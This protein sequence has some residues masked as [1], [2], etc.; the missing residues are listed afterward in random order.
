MAQ[1]QQE[2][3][4]KHK[5]KFKVGVQVGVKFKVGVQVQVGVYG[6]SS[7]L[8][9]KLSWRLKLELGDIFDNLK[10]I[11][12]DRGSGLLLEVPFSPVP[13]PV[14]T[15]TPD[16]VSNRYYLGLA[17]LED[18]TWFLAIQ[19][20]SEKAPTDWDYIT[21]SR[22]QDGISVLSFIAR[23]KSCSRNP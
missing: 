11:R 5:S 1:D 19:P 21:S 10:V 13:T 17:P 16:K 8:S 15:S 3:R 22:L 9:L 23:A 2:S 12:I 18:I 4:F 7:S 20:G 14:F 6:W